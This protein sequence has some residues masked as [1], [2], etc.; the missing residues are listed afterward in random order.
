MRLTQ[1]SYVTIV[2]ILMLSAMTGIALFTVCC[3]IFNDKLP[4]S[5]REAAVETSVTK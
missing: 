4:V 2:S 3:K 5:G 1:K